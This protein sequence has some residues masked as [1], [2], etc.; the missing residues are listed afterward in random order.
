MIVIMDARVVELLKNRGIP[1]RT[2]EWLEA[3]S[4]LL[5]ASE[6]SAALKMTPTACS[7]YVKEFGLEN[8]FVYNP[9]KSCNPYMSTAALIKKKSAPSAT[10]DISNSDFMAWGTLY[11]E[12]ARQIY[13]QMTGETV[14]D[15]GLLVHPKYP[16]LFGASPDGVTSS[17]KVLEIKVPSVRVPG[18]IVQLQYAFQ[19]YLQ[20]DVTGLDRGDFFD[21]R[22]IEWTSKDEWLVSAGEQQVS[23]FHTHGI[24]C[25]D[26]ESLKYSYAP[27]DTLTTEQFLT[28]AHS[29]QSLGMRPV[30]YQMVAYELIGITRDPNWLTDNLD[31]LRSV[32]NAIKRAREMPKTMPPSDETPAPKRAKLIKP[33]LRE[34]LI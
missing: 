20:M 4:G 34:C 14:H 3:R 24:V 29:K 30:Y 8:S 25:Q 10:T 32:M 16:D 27:D 22:I 9:R 17:G 7:H 28:W 31:E 11:E 33:I 18:T 13:V 23:R 19:M 26:P 5:T 1:Q 21:V 6:I 12:V 2:P 15:F